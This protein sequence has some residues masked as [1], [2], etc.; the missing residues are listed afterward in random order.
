MDGGLCV[1]FFLQ[2]AEIGGLDDGFG[3][4]SCCLIRRVYEVSRDGDGSG[5]LVHAVINHKGHKE[6][7]RS[8]K[9][10]KS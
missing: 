1:G 9:S 6:S 5:G 10:K 2:G 4:R 7:T 8:T 3:G